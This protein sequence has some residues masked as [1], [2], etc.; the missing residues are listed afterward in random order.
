[1]KTKLND[2]VLLLSKDESY[3]VK[4]EHD[5]HIKSGMISLEKLLKLKFGQ[6]IKTNIGKEFFVVKQTILDIIERKFKRGAQVI[7]PKDIGLIIGYTGIGN[8]SLVVDAGSGSGY[9]SLFLANYLAKGKVVTYE[10]DKRFQEIV[11]HNIKISGLKNIVLKKAN[12]NKGISER[13]IDLVTLD[14]QHPEKIIRHSYKSLKVGGW[15]VVYSPTAEELM[16][17]VKAIRKIGFSK[18]KE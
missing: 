7:L 11:K 15:L 3:V 16:R 14:L 5:I 10:K 6:K 18:E 12:V 13:N 1:M 8:D 4:I 9:L 2:K 17:V